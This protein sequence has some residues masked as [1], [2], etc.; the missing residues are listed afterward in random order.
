MQAVILAG[1][2]GTRLRPYTTTLPKPLVPVG[3]RPILSIIL[4]QLRSAGCTKVTMAVNH[5]AEL[6]MAFFGN[7]NKLGIE[8][9]YSIEE[10]PLGTVGPLRLIDD[11]PEHFLV[12][13]GDILSDID[14][15]ALF[16]QHVKSGAVLTVATYKRQMLVDFGVINTSASG[17]L[18]G[19]TEKPSLDFE[20]ST[21]IYVFRRKVLE[22]VPKNQPFG[23]D[24]LVHL[25]L[26]EKRLIRC[27]KHAGY[28]LDLGRPDDF[29]RANEDY[30]IVPSLQ[31]GA[32]A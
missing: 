2:R 15:S 21:G 11:L 17:R 25:L 10:K 29:D 12:M 23:F 32:S 16:R 24:E 5:L 20:V 27:Y 31:L 6:I 8:I 14:Y 19:F 3:E 13:N 18:C 7:G 30:R 4:E 28:W 9:N 26:Q 1:G 22:Y